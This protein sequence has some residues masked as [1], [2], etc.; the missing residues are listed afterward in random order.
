MRLLKSCVTLMCLLLMAARVQAAPIGRAT[1]DFDNARPGKAE[2]SWGRFV[3]DSLRSGTRADIALVNAGALQSGTLKQGDIS[4]ADVDALLS[5]GADNVVTMT[6]SGA[7]LRAALERG[8]SAHPTNSPA[9]L[10]AAGLTANFDSQA[11]AGRRIREV[12][13]N[14]QPLRDDAAFVCA[15]PVALAEGAGGYFAIWNGQADTPSGSTLR[16]T[17]LSLIRARQTI[18]PDQA[19]RIAPQ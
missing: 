17:V 12:R 7:Q 6:I 13:V 2:T 18:S 4:A 3:A 5:Y 8:V 14:G 1:A 10:H 11:P 19:P 16:E 9:F 15:M